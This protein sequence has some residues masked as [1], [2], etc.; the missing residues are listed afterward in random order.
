MAGSKSI[1]TGILATKLSA[2]AR[3]KFIEWSNNANNEE[4]DRWV[5]LFL[6]TEE[7]QDALGEYAI[8][9]M[10]EIENHCDIKISAFIRVGGNI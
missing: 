2:V 3:I 1:L 8:E 9:Q 6:T 7:V 10:Q 4:F 5:S